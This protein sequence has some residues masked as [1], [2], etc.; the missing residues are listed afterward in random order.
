MRVKFAKKNSEKEHLQGHITAIH[1][2][3]KPHEC[4]FCQN[5]FSEKGSLQKRKTAVHLKE[6]PLEC[7]SE[8]LFG[9]F[10]TDEAS[11]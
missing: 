10:H 5:I 8:N 3:E 7:E 6:K 9:K 11:L 4:E 1:L 2:K